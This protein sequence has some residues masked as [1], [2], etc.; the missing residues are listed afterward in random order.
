MKGLSFSTE[1]ISS[2]E[3]AT[4]AESLDAVQAKKSALLFLCKINADWRQVEDFLLRYPEALLFE[5]ADVEEGVQ[6]VIEAQ[7]LRC[8][9]FVS[10][11]NSNRRR[12]MI[13]LKRGFEYYR[14]VMFTKSLREYCFV[15]PVSG[16]RRWEIYTEQLTEL[17][18]ELRVIAEKELR[19]ISRIEKA[20]ITV[21]ECR[22]KLESASR[23]ENV[24]RT[25]LALLKCQ[26]PVDTFEKTSHLEKILC[27]ATLSILSLDTEYELL[28]QERI[29]AK[30]LQHALLKTCFAGCQR[31][32]CDA[33]RKDFD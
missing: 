23:Q 8:R 14:S 27:A 9:C 17:A 10:E 11:C 26:R 15:T 28:A 3:S 6:N 29:A 31:H 13:L 32:V 33:T 25:P 19:T 24:I 22:L 30:R 4:M 21:K 2:S 12:L 20:R 1:S 7:M 5:G 18:R 16:P